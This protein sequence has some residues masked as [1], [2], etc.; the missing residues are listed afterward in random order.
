MKTLNILIAI[1]FI[2][3]LACTNKNN[4]Y[5]YT[6]KLQADTSILKLKIG[7]KV[8]PLNKQVCYFEAEN[9][10]FLSYHDRK[11][12]H[13]LFFSLDNDSLINEIYFQKKGPNKIQTITGMY[14]ANFDSIYLFTLKRSQ[15]I[16]ID[17][18]GNIKEIIDF[19]DINNGKYPV[20]I[21]GIIN[22]I[23]NPIIKIGNDLYFA[24][25]PPVSNEFNETNNISL[26]LMFNTKTKKTSLSSFKYPKVSEL[27]DIANVYFSRDY[28]GEKWVYSFLLSHDL[29]I[30][31]KNGTSYRKKAKSKYAANNLKIPRKNAANPILEALKPRYL[32]LIYDKWENV[33]YRIYLHETHTTKDM[34]SEELFAL[35]DSPETFSVIILDELLNVIGETKMT[36]NRYNP[37]MFFVDKNGLHFALHEKNPKFSPDYLQFASFKI[38]KIK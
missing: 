29:F 4:N 34:T 25:R 13:M 23:N 38:T 36:K 12:H 10:H 33:F 30:Y 14:F 32:S 19:S 8:L 5:N 7:T 22:Q 6:Y 26:G 35:I 28:D 20:A 27:G 37:E 24:T 9:K 18:N 15:V 3:L 31:N 11:S 17:F 21:Y 1:L 2:L 16:R